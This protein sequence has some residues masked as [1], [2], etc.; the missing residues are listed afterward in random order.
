[1]L[2]LRLMTG[3]KKS[4]QLVAMSLSQIDGVCKDN[5]FSFR[6]RLLVDFNFAC[7]PTRRC[8]LMLVSRASLPSMY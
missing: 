3:R 7:I 6:F 8:F 2:R 5:E 1:M 4:W